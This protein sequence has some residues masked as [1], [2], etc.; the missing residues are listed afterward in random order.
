MNGLQLQVRLELWTSYAT[1][2]LDIIS[3][4]D[5][6]QA[7]IA[8]VSHLFLYAA[9]SFERVGQDKLLLSKLLLILPI[10]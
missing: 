7:G 10:F 8:V 2:T 9:L 4:K 1:Y 6:G 3:E 5:D